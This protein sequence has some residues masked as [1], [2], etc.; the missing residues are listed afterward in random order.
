MN[1]IKL[2]EERI[3]EFREYFDKYSHEQD[4]S[5]PPLDNYSVRDDESGFLL[6]GEKNEI[7]GYSCI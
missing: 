3:N 6:I 7:I 4:E 5:F 1:V 2:T